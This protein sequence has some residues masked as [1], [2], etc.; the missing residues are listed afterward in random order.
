M[1]R[2]E[3]GNLAPSQGNSK[4]YLEVGEKSGN[5]VFL[6]LALGLT[7]VFIVGKEILLR[8]LF[9][10]LLAFRQRIQHAWSVLV[11]LL[12]V[13]SQGISFILMSSNPGS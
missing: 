12:S 9:R 4:S 11:D 5:L 10:K 6:Y 2:E 7:R 13:K 1:V 8:K 3:S